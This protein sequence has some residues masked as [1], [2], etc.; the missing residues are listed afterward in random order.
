MD[1]EDLSE[2][3]DW[4]GMGWTAAAV[5]VIVLSFFGGMVFRTNLTGGPDEAQELAPG[6]LIERNIQTAG[7]NPGP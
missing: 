2:K 7:Q 5:L 4:S 6:T 3:R 1:W